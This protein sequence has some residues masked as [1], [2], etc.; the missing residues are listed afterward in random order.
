MNLADIC[1]QCNLCTLD[2]CESGDSKPVLKYD[3][4][5]NK[6]KAIE[7]LFILSLNSKN[8]NEH[9]ES[10]AELKKGI[11]FSLTYTIRCPLQIVK[12]DELHLAKNRCLFYTRALLMSYRFFVIDKSSAETLGI[13]DYE[14][15][16]IKQESFGWCLFVEGGI[17][18]ICNNFLS[19]TTLN[20]LLEIKTK[21]LLRV[22]S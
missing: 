18:E 2:D 21:K 15:G 11:N 5:A 20:Q 22:V 6:D 8:A 14:Q 3:Y 9:C 10:L 12:I 4:V 19:S 17:D 1:S 16:K 13:V 7:L